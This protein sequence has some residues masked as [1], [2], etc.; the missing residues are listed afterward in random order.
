MDKSI[1]Y[2]LQESTGHAQ[3]SEQNLT[4]A[5]EYADSNPY[6]GLKFN[7]KLMEAEVKNYFVDLAK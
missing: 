4:D 1:F 6:K 5:R 2:M 3:L 7:V